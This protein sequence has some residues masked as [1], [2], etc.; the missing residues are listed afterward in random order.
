MS[1]AVYRE[2]ETVLAAHSRFLLAVSKVYLAL[3]A[4]LFS[5]WWLNTGGAVI[6]TL[7]LLY[8]VFFGT[9]SE[10]QD[11]SF[12]QAAIDVFKNNAA[13][14]LLLLFWCA[15]SGTGGIGFQNSDYAASNA[16]LKDLVQNPWPLQMNGNVPMVYYV[17]YYLP[18]ALVGK[19]FGWQ[20]ANLFLFIWTYFGLLLLWSLFSLATR[21]DQLSA[22]RKLLAASAFILFG[23]WDFFGA[24]I[25]YGSER[26]SV[27][28]HIEWWASIGQFSS[29]T[30]LLFWVPQHVIAPW[31]VTAS[32]LLTLQRDVGQG[33][34][35]FLA[36]LSF[37]WSP[38]ASLGLLPFLGLCAV[39]DFRAGR[40]EANF[41]VANVFVGP[42]LA[43]IGLLFYSSNAFKFPNSWQFTEPDFFRNYIL[44]FIFEA[45]AIALP[46]FS[47]H[48]RAQVYLN[49]I[50]L[51]PPV[52]LTPTEKIMG[53]IAL[54]SLFI[55]PLYKMGFMND[56]CMRASVPALLVLF[57]F[58]VRVL[59]R[60]FSYQYFP[61]AVLFFC[62]LIGSGSA[63]QEILRSTNNFSIQVPDVNNVSSLLNSSDNSIIDQRA[64]NKNSFFWKWFGPHKE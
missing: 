33:V 31:I 25:T 37:L 58:W 62:T 17:L 52:R 6:G 47:Q 9:S 43:L 4:L 2:N 20:A 40:I 19:L 13:V 3:P 12:Y 42:A 44:L 50:D 18:A 24:L 48:L 63:I 32:L 14:A 15:L 39:R 46:F 57:S 8:G 45:L 53:W 36:A 16:L 59:R 11:S 64:G 38:I 10:N 61:I 49:Q 28:T 26:L 54:A 55:L 1:T 5:L 30:T 21:I 56:L 7:L 35:W 51:P 27:G 22:G 29:S 23:G 41:S 60:E 34:I